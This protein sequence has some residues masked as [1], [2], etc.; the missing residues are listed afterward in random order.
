M[1]SKALL[2]LP[3]KWHGLR[4]TEAKYRQRYLDLIANEQSA[5]SSRSA[6]ARSRR[7]AATS[8]TAASS[9]SKR[10]AAADPAARRPALR[11]ALRGANADMYLR[12]APELYSSACSSAGST[13]C[14]S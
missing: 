3:E 1:L 14:S 11:D 9:K 5:T 2:S 13:R 10:P 12:I 4:D 6:S 7:S 8:P